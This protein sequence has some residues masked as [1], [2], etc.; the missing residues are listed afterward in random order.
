MTKYKAKSILIGRKKSLGDDLD[1]RPCFV[2]LFNGNDPHKS[3]EVPFEILEFEKVHKVVIEKLQLNYLL[4]GNDL[5]VN[6]LEFIELRSD[7]PHVFL[8]GK[9][10][11]APKK[12][13][14]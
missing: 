5:V 14:G 1:V 13:K 8:T 9:Q 2:S 3:G 10:S 12:T 6:N 4:P 7:G 11:N